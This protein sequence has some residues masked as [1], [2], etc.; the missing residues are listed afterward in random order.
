MGGR[1]IDLSTDDPYFVVHIGP[2]MFGALW[3]R[4]VFER[5]TPVDRK[6]RPLVD[7]GER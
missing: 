3:N 6:S 7:D 1:S 2:F 4:P 5:Y